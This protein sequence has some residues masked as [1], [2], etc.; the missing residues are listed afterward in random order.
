MF[1]LRRKDMGSGSDC[2]WS[3]GIFDCFTVLMSSGL[4]SCWRSPDGTVVERKRKWW[5]LPSL[6]VD[7]LR[8]EGS[9]VEGRSAVF[10]FT[11][12]DIFRWIFD[13]IFEMICGVVLNRNLFFVK[14]GSLVNPIILLMSNM[15]SGSCA[16]LS[17]PEAWRYIC[18][19]SSVRSEGTFR[20]VVF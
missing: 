12:I 17:P 13:E 18:I 5:F 1:W 15:I 9:D 6:R 7:R 11:V 16:G 10:F 20:N 8:N 2:R 3:G 19:L 4:G 14:A